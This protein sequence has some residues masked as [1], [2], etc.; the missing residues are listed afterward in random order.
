MSYRVFSPP[1]NS[2]GYGLSTSFKSLFSG[3]PQPPGF[4]TLP[5]SRAGIFFNG[6]Y[7]GEGALGL[8]IFI[9]NLGEVS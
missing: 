3:F 5:V 9:G 6:C 1:F 2:S 7:F 4:M 8:M